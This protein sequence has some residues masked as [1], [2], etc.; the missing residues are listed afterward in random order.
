M[1]G[2]CR[3]ACHDSSL[4][5]FVLV[6]FIDSDVCSKKY[7]HHSTCSVC[8]LVTLIVVLCT[9]INLACYDFN[10]YVY[11]CVFVFVNACV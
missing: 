8:S 2:V 7:T 5:L 10:L 4:Y 11:V 9:V 3:P 1:F 6:I